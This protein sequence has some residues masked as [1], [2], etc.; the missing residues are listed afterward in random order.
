M[1]LNQR[2]G[3]SLN[4]G[5]E[6]VVLLK[7][8]KRTWSWSRSQSLG[9]AWWLCLIH[10]VCSLLI[11]HRI[12]K[13]CSQFYTCPHFVLSFTPRQ[14]GCGKM[15][16]ASGVSRCLVREA[17]GPGLVQ[18]GKGQL[19]GHLTADPQTLLE[20]YL[21]AG[22]RLFPVIHGRS[23]RD[24]RAKL[25]WEVQTE[26][27]K[28][29]PHEDTQALEQGPERLSCHQPRAWSSVPDW[30]DQVLNNLISQLAL[31]WAGDQA[32]D[33]LRSLP[34]WMILWSLHICLISFGWYDCS[35]EYSKLKAF[36]RENI[37]S[38]GVEEIHFFYLFFF[39]QLGSFPVWETV[40]QRTDYRPWI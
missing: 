13:C 26:Y 28:L 4:H 36:I 9:M 38:R 3:I 33:L 34:A 27:E 6:I 22:S 35:A 21:E 8:Y 37:Y 20:S 30:M 15:Q 17:E 16:R 2:S 29:V 23:A 5:N 31:L 18:D 19:W 12:L 24:Y 7:E 40:T 32:R 1:L 11:F 10:I 39:F 14:R 25:K